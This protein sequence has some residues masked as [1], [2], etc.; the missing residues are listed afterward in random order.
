MSAEDS[1]PLVSVILPAFRSGATIERS[2]ESIDQQTFRDFET[3]VVE[4]SGD[5]ASEAMVHRRFPAVRFIA[6]SDRLLP[7]AARNLGVGHSRGRLLVFTDPDIYLQSRWLQALVTAW[8]EQH[9]VIIGS[10]ACHGTR[11]IDFGFHLTKFSKWLPA[12]R[13][14]ILDMAPSGNMLVSR[15]DF[16][17]AGA[18]PGE[19]FIGDVELSRNLQ[20][21]GLRLW[22]EPAAAGAHH[23]L[24]TLRE[25]CAE[26]FQRGRWYGELR[27][28]WYVDRR[29]RIATLAVATVLPLR[30]ASNL[31]RVALHAARGGALIKLV[32]A[33]PVVVAGYGA[34]LAG[35]AGAYLA[36]LA[37]RSR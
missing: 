14:R 13:R 6:A 7:Q 33:L 11:V 23:H 10:F 8:E 30:L 4:S 18:F 1:S 16:E 32:T 19:L 34:T 12:G 5:A 22:F 29:W 15:E 35:E 28:R 24:Y 27:S 21:C 3:I 37:R 25:F 31:A 20:D 26:R 9:E 17:R 36:A 2:L